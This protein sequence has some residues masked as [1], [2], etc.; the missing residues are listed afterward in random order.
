MAR[1]PERP[2]PPSTRARAPR[3]AAPPA[4]VSSSLTTAPTPPRDERTAHQHSTPSTPPTSHH[5]VAVHRV[6]TES[7]LVFAYRTRSPLDQRH[8][9]S[10]SAELSAPTRTPYP[11][12]HSTPSHDLPIIR[13]NCTYR[14]RTISK[15]CPHLPHPLPPLSSLHLQPTAGHARYPHR[16]SPQHHLASALPSVLSR[17]AVRAFDGGGIGCSRSGLQVYALVTTFSTAGTQRWRRF[18]RVILSLQLVHIVSRPSGFYYLVLFIT[19]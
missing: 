13:M 17:C 6:H 1:T 11:A 8:R 2:I 16:Q 5:P 14:G 4:P 15:H 7:P 12:H 10:H 19:A 18:I 9:I 3:P